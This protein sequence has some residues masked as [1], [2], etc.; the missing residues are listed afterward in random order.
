MVPQDS[1]EVKWINQLNGW[2]LSRAPRGSGHEGVE[3]CFP[4]NATITPA[5]KQSKDN[6][7]LALMVPQNTK[8]QVGKPAKW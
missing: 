6:Q 3:L 7:V 5:T 4:K 1:I 2:M 8:S